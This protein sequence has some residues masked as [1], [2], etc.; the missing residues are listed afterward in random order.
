MASGMQMAKAS[1]LEIND[2]MKFLTCLQMAVED[3]EYLI[4]DDDLDGETKH[5]PSCSRL[6]KFIDNWYGRLRGAERIVWGYKTL[7]D[8]VCDPDSD[9]LELRKD[10]THCQKAN[11]YASRYGIYAVPIMHGKTRYW[12]PRTPRGFDVPY[13]WHEAN[14]P[15]FSGWKS[16]ADA[17]VS[18]GEAIEQGKVEVS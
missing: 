11:E 16:W 17:M 3:G 15:T 18:L 9:V 1:E 2:L 5:D 6:G 4:D 7:I 8:N 13:S 12:R 10:V 14:S